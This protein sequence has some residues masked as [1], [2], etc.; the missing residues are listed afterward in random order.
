MLTRAGPPRA[1]VTAWSVGDHIP[2]GRGPIGEDVTLPG[3]RFSDGVRENLQELGEFLDPQDTA[4]LQ[5]AGQEG[6]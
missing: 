6:L 4:P 3:I 5:Q 2:R 1:H